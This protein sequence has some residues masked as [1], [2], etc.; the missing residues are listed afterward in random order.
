M[1]INKSIFD[2]YLLPEGW[3]S[4]PPRDEGDPA[5][6]APPERAASIRMTEFSSD[7]KPD[8]WF[9]AEILERGKYSEATTLIE[10][11]GLPNAILVNCHAQKA[12]LWA[13]LIS[14]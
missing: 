12:Q 10:K 6:P 13:E 5:P 7:D 4:M 3:L 9:K 11:Y 2:F 14:S 1:S 8:I